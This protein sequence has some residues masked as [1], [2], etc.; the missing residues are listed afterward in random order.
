M[1]EA[2]ERLRKYKLSQKEEVY[3]CPDRC[4]NHHMRTSK[5]TIAKIEAFIEKKAKAYKKKKATEREEKEKQSKVK[6]AK[7]RAIDL[8]CKEIVARSK[9]YD[10]N[11]SRTSFHNSID[12]FSTFSELGR[13]KKERD[14]ERDIKYK[15]KA[16]PQNQAD[17]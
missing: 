14:R 12:H 4:P 3:E 11:I 1:M 9:K 2:K 13:V 16:N 5:K 8:K 6:D 17:L 7:L 10:P 15:R